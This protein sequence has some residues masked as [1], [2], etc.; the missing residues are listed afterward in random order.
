MNNVPFIGPRSRHNILVNE[1]TWVY[2]IMA[3]GSTLSGEVPRNPALCEMEIDPVLANGR[4]EFQQLTSGGLFALLSNYGLAFTVEEIDNPDSATIEIIGRDGVKIR[5]IPSETPFKVV[6][7][8]EIL[9][10][11]G[12]GTKVGFMVRRYPEKIV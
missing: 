9:K 7:S 6:G 8:S 4:F 3:E 12:G 5:D 1:P 10:V 2:H 11:S